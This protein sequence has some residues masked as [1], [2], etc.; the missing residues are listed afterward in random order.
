MRRIDDGGFSSVPRTEDTLHPRLYVHVKLRKPLAAI[1]AL[2]RLAAP[3]DDRANDRALGDRAGGRDLLGRGHNHVAQRAPALPADAV[4][5][6]AH[7]L[8]HPGIIG[9]P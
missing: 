1:G 5:V 9:Y 8:L 2:H 4:H 6:D 3:H 7:N